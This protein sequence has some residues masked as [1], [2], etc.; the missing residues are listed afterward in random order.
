METINIRDIMAYD[1]IDDIDVSAKWDDTDYIDDVNDQI[2]I[3]WVID[4]TL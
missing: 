4:G 1:D 2:I 3:A